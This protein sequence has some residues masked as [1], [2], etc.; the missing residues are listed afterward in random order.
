MFKVL[1]TSLVKLP[2]SW[3]YAY[4]IYYKLRYCTLNNSVHVNVQKNIC[5]NSNLIC[6]SKTFPFPVRPFFHQS[7]TNEVSNVRST[8]RIWPF[9]FTVLHSVRFFPIF[10]GVCLAFSTCKECGSD[11]HNPV[12]Q[13]S[14]RAYFLPFFPARGENTFLWFT[15]P[16][17]PLPV[18]YIAKK[19]FHSKFIG[20]RWAKSDFIQ[21]LKG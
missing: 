8:D 7:L 4:H 2:S 1:D 18:R 15:I 12:L 19:S 20:V 5:L 10:N 16:F 14:L 11:Y 9:N 13:V 3:L 6:N 21:W 17:R